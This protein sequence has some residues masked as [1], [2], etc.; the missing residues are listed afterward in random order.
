MI[1]K[2]APTALFLS[3]AIIIPAITNAGKDALGQ[4]TQ[5]PKKK[6]ITKNQR[7]AM[8]RTISHLIQMY[9][10]VAISLLASH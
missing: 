6:N 1:S 3:G 2:T 4:K 10:F 8:G 7:T 9:A 5:V